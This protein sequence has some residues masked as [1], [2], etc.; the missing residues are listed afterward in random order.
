MKKT[1]LPISATVT[2]FPSFRLRQPGHPVIPGIRGFPP[3]N[4][5]WFGFFGLNSFIYTANTMPFGK[6]YLTY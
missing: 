6:Y 4:R 5:S 1:E 3:H 2:R